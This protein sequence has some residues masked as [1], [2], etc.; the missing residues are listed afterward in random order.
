MKK[1]LLI[2]IVILIVILGGVL[3][4][5]NSKSDTNN[6]NDN[7]NNSNTTE[8][9]ENTFESQNVGNIIFEDITYDYDGNISLLEYT[10]VNKTD[11]VINLGSYEIVVKD[12]NGEAIANMIGFVDKDINPN[13]EVRTGNT[14][15]MDLS[16]A[17]SIELVLD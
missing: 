9:K 4:F 14:I 1:K 6:T 3:I 8:K 10:I 2:V 5:V 17:K 12:K 16:E 15:S 7:K 11:K 13:E